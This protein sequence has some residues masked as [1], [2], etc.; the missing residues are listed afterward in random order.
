MSG[1]GCKCGC[2]DF[3]EHIGDGPY[4]AAA[5][6]PTSPAAQKTEFANVGEKHLVKDR[7]TY[8]ELRS[9]GIQPERLRG[10][11]SLAARAKDTHEIE[12]GQLMDKEQIRVEKEVKAI[13][14]GKS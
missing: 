1:Y 13:A 3:K 10:V 12:Q 11:H 4:I 6:R 5:A 2:A 14:N 9:Q 7:D 8:K